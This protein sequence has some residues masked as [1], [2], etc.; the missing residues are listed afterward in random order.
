M[1]FIHSSFCQK[2]EWMIVYQ[3]NIKLI[4]EFDG[5]IDLGD[6]I[7]YMDSFVSYVYKMAEARNIF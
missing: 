4:Q 5:D 1:G 6:L 2:I 7:L 3:E